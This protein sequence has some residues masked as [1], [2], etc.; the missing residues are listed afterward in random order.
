M[1]SS[2][3]YN[4]KYQSFLENRNLTVFM[5]LKIRKYPKIKKLGNIYGEVGAQRS[6]E[7][8]NLF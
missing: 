2:R 1:R 5:N 8:T 7:P 6:D 3:T 4:F